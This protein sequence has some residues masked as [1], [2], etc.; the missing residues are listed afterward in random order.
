MITTPKFR[1]S[2]GNIFQIFLYF[3]T[4]RALY[5]INELAIWLG[6]QFTNYGGLMDI[7]QREIL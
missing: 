1:A 7:L 2:L 6:S 4:V 3:L 5:S